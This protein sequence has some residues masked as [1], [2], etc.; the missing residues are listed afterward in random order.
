MAR[1]DCIRLDQPQSRIGKC[2]SSPRKVN[3]NSLEFHRK[4]CSGPYR[5]RVVTPQS[6]RDRCRG[7][8]EFRYAYSLASY[9][10]SFATAWGLLLQTFTTFG[11]TQCGP[12]FIMQVDERQLY[13]NTFFR[14]ILRFE[15]D[16]HHNLPISHHGD[17]SLVES[18][19]GRR[20]V[21]SINKLCQLRRT[22]MACLSEL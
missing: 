13:F 14:G 6:Q 17:A 5:D 18:F 11:K 21:S 20:N 12:L 16:F 4:K 15:F 9:S 3:L 7:V 19:C 2:E 10:H 8:Q 22:T 1:S